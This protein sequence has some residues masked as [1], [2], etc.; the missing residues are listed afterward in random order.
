[1]DYSAY[2]QDAWPQGPPSKRGVIIKVFVALLIIGLI[3]GAFFIG[4][5]AL[6]PPEQQC[7]V[8]PACPKQQECP[9][10]ATSTTTGESC[11]AAVPCPQPDLAQIC[12]KCQ[13]PEA[14]KPCDEKVCPSCPSCPSCPTCATCPDIR[15]GNFVYGSTSNVDIAGNDIYDKAITGGYTEWK[16][17]CDA[18][19]LCKGFNSNGWLKKANYATTGTWTSSTGTTFYTKAGLA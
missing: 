17:F 19:P 4:G 15:T 13:A 14:C 10:V 8:A 11:P 6:N 1:M 18:N 3:I 16:K 12:P 9:T 7:P 5:E 2:N